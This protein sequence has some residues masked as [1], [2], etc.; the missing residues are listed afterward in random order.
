MI[1]KKKSEMFFLKNLIKVKNLIFSVENGAKLYE[2][3][4]KFSV[5]N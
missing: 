2:K 3:R 5:A 1:C 4:N